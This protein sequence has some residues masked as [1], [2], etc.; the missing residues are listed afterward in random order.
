MNVAEGIV[1][2]YKLLLPEAHVPTRSRDTDAGHDLYSAEEKLI[3]PKSGVNI[4][5]GIAI[6]APPGYYYTIE[7][8]SSMWQKGIMQFSGIID[9]TY[10]GEL[11]VG[12]LNISDYSFLAKPGDRIAQMIIHKIIQGGFNKVDEWSKNYSL[13]GEAGWGSSGR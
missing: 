13:R 5:T 7:G 2:E 8:R 10:T 4:R 6:S 1:L 3:K 9:G 11:H 12:L